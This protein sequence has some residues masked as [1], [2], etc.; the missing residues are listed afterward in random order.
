MPLLAFEGVSKRYL[1]LGVHEHVVLDDV[2]FELEAGT[3]AGIWGLR[4]SGKSTLLR[5]AAGIELP[6]A[7]VV[8]FEGR[9]ITK[10]SDRERAR[11]VRTQIGLA[12]SSWRETATCASWST[13]GCRC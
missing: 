2:S 11:L 4:R 6:D 10:L 9:D 1:D 13:S 5:I 12:P 7:G 3:S 8:R